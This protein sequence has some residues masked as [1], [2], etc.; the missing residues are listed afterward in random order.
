MLKIFIK[1]SKKDS[2]YETSLQSLYNECHC[3]QK[4]SIRSSIRTLVSTTLK[5]DTDAIEAATDAVKI[6]ELTCRDL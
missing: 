3:K 6:S 5:N 4:D 2:P 1:F